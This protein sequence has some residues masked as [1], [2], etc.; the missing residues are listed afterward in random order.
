MKIIKKNILL[1]V[2]L[3][4]ALFFSVAPLANAQ[5]MY[6]GGFHTVFLPCTSTSNMWYLVIPFYLQGTGGVPTGATIT[7]TNY[8][9]LTRY[10]NFFIHSGNWSTGRLAS[11]SSQCQIYLVYTTITIPNMYTFDESTIG[12][13]P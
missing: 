11:N 3:I 2:G 9:G 6:Y 5:G 13:S 1:T 10:A 8:S 7:T 12:T 4:I